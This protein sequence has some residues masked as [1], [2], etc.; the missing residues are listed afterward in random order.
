MKMEFS[1]DEVVSVIKE[2]IATKWMIPVESI[3]SVKWVVSR[4]AAGGTMTTVV[5][6][7]KTDAGS[8]YRKK[9]VQ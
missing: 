2:H 4:N 6:E 1:G 8:P 5:A 7:I 9:A 3:L